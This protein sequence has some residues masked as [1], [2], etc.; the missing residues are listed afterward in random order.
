MA[1]ADQKAVKAL[2]ER[3][4]AMI[5]L[6]ERGQK[7]AIAFAEDATSWSGKWALLKDKVGLEEDAHTKFLAEA[8]ARYV[9]TGEDLQ[10][11]LDNAVKGYLSD[12]NGIENEV[13]V[14]LRADLADEA[15]GRGVKPPCLVSDEAF[16]REYRRLAAE[17]TPRLDRD[18]KVTAGRE[19][20]SFVAMDVATQVVIRIARVAA[21][22]LGVEA[23]ILGAGAASTLTTLGVGLV[24]GI[25]VDQVIAWVMKQAGYDPAGEIASKVRESLNTLK[26]LLLEGAQGKSGLRR[27]L[28]RIQQARSHL[29]QQV[30]DKLLSEGGNP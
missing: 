12:L 18:L 27:E 7:G 25:I 15:L 24:V 20:A 13:L 11:T 1:T 8:F 9:L 19:V 26:A 29:R 2:E 22:E 5:S 16:G 4:H 17:L 30:I 28:Q 3:L 6:F 21:A 14:Q 10:S 23:A